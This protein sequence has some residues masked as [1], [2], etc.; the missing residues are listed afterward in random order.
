MIRSVRNLDSKSVKE[1][2]TPLVDMIGIEASESISN[3]HQLCLATQFSRMPVFQGRFDS[4][5]G[6]VSMKTLL[7][8]ACSWKEGEASPCYEELTVREIADK[9]YFVPETMSLLNALRSLKERTLAICV[10]EYGGTTGLVTL[11]DVLEEI[12]GEIYDPEEEK[13]ALEREK[14]TSKIS[15]IGPGRFVMSATADIEDVN[16]ILGI[17]LPSGDYNSV[18]GFVCAVI[19]RIPA[20]GEAITAQT[21]LESIRFE[22]VEAD[23]RKIIK[24]EAY[25]ERL[26]AA[27]LSR[28][29]SESE[30]GEQGEGQ[31]DK[32]DEDDRSQ[33]LDVR[34]ESEDKEISP[35]DTEESEE[36]GIEE[37]VVSAP[38]EP[39]AQAGGEDAAGKSKGGG[40]GDDGA[41]AEPGSEKRAESQAEST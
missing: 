37:G 34:A 33:V 40:G 27:E 9:P 6:V 10:D 23:E 22:V 7:K 11:E 17:E 41:H 20:V 36:E 25:S 39:F 12:V 2:M 30:D 26:A 35:W 13:D 29:A 28:L 38:A 16:D 14:N 8:H 4:I 21:A 1:V 3:L 19:D 5:V 24:V 32:D 18:G 15:C 31:R